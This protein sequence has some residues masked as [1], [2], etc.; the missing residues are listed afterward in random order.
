MRPRS[1]H[2]GRRIDSDGAKGRLPGERAEGDDYAKKLGFSSSVEGLAP[3]TSRDGITYTSVRGPVEPPLRRWQEGYLVS[4]MSGFNLA[5]PGSLAVSS[6]TVPWGSLPANGRTGW[7]H[8]G[9][10]ITA[11]GKVATCH[12]AEPRIL[13][14]D[15]TGRLLADWPLDGREGH[16]ITATRDPAGEDILWI[17]DP[18]FKLGITGAA[19][20][21][22]HEGQGRVSS[23]DLAGRHLAELETPPHPAYVDKPYKPTGIAVADGPGEGGDV[24][25]VD[26]YGQ[27]LVHRYSADGEYLASL[28]G[29]SGAGRFDGPHG[30]TIVRRHAPEPEI[31][32]CDRENRR[33]QV[34]DLDG[35]YRR[36]VGAGSLTSPSGVLVVGD[37][38]IVAE[39]KA[40]LVVLEDD[41]IVGTIGADDRAPQR[42]GWPNRLDE[43]GDMVPPGEIPAGRF[44]SPHAMATDGHGTL[45]VSEFLLGGRISKLELGTEEAHR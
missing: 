45:F 4:L 24:W 16:G 14:L 6:W 32:V 3:L 27:S 17:A 19:V 21:P 8:P 37:R 35:H 12:P 39:L 20:S 43:A 13:I 11:S 7:A 26:G 29:E 44:N 2:E 38:L 28:D 25:I 22:V 23:W 15:L 33:I 9:L 41:R 36:T 40:R 1:R 34:F 18:G 42:P 31:Y 10:A 5:E 30:A